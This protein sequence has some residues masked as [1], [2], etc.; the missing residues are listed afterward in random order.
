MG[1]PL[2]AGVLSSFDGFDLGGFLEVS[3]VFDDL[4]DSSGHHCFFE[5]AN[6]VPSGLIFFGSNNDWHCNH[7]PSEYLFANNKG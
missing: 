6:Q 1:S 7:L 5:L 3:S 2:E 4:Y